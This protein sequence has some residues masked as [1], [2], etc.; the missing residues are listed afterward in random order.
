MKNTAVL[1]L[2]IFL[3]IAAAAGGFKVKLIK[4]KKP[5]KFQ[6]HLAAAG[7]TFAADLLLE[8]KEQEKYFCRQLTPSDIIAVRLAVFNRGTEKVELPLEGL[9]LLSPDGAEIPP[10][11]PYVVAE[12]V[13]KGMV[14]ASADRRKNPP[15][16]VSPGVHDP[17][18]RS[19]PTYDPRLDPTDPNY[20]PNDPRNRRIR[21]P[22]MRPGV[23]VVLNPG[24][25][26]G[27]ANLS[28]NEKL[29]IEKDFRDK[30][31][32]PEAVLPSMTRDRFLYFS[33]KDRPK[34]GKGFELILPPGRGIP[35]KIVLRF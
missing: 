8:G 17:R 27:K 26:V 14:V 33:L 35:Q 1:L 19:D 11:D 6:C 23:D 18:D 34:N 7:V 9:Q 31:H 24:G 22:Y 21:G 16:A 10:V 29:L 12:A 28:E 13:T 5:E 3:P 32:D 25:G 2:C 30:A 15:V 4:P 20:D